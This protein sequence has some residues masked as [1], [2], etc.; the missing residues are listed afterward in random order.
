M[1]LAILR[2]RYTPFGGA[3]RFLERAIAAL[4]REDMEITVITR[5]WPGSGVSGAVRILALNPFY[6][7]S[8][9]RDAGFARASCRAV[10]AGKFDL[11]QSHE[12]IACCDVYRAGDGVH[13]EWLMQRAR[14]R[15]LVGRSLD[16]LNPYHRYTLAAERRLFTSP[17]L[18][19]V[20]CNAHMVR[21]EIQRHFGVD[22][23]KLHVIYNGVD[24]DAFHPGLRAEYR[25]ALRAQ[26]GLPEDAVV[27]L[28]VG[29]GFERKG[30]PLLLD[31]WP[32]LPAHAHL[33]VAGRD[34]SMQR[35][36]KRAAGSGGRV[37]FVGAQKDVRPWY[38]LADVFVLPT[39]YDPCSNAALEALSC[40][41]PVLTSSKCGAS[42]WIVAGQN[43]D[44]A[45]ALDA[46]KWRA[47]LL[48]WLAPE[49]RRQA[50]DAARASALPLTLE[51]MQQSYRDLYARLLTPQT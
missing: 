27:Y 38:G 51:A 19:A 34:R 20:V 17:G 39:L 10:A 9:W 6:L 23:T 21:E 24:T 36:V 33:V 28:F 35:C 12:R 47:I 25:S 29:S 40:G 31:L 50:R 1:K 3:E 49:R 14:Q 45:D 42:E 30:V 16:R 37:H 11:V 13:R 18:K 48:A 8:T 46:Q 43:G 7:G 32:Q 26:L 2:Q 41:L 4:G 22:R 15:G 44:V 5:S